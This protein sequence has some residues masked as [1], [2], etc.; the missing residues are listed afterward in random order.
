MIRENLL[1]GSSTRY[2][3][4]AHRI[5]LWPSVKLENL[6]PIDIFYNI[7]GETGHVKAG[8]QAAITTVSSS[9]AFLLSKVNM[10]I[11]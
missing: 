2:D 5:Y 11:F 3:Q 6:L 4:P 8:A 10:I 7:S 1:I 9:V